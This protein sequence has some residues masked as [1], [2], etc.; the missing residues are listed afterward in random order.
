MLS[1]VGQVNHYNVHVGTPRC[2][3]DFLSAQPRVKLRAISRQQLRI[4][5]RQL[6]S[7]ILNPSAAQLHADSKHQPGRDS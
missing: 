1:R 2:Y 5:L 3:V 4:P 7:R 6:L